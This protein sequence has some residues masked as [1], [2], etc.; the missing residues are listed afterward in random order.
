MSAQVVTSVGGSV[1]TITINRS[2]SPSDLDGAARAQLMLSLAAVAVDRTVLAVV[3]RGDGDDFCRGRDLDEY[4]AR[5]AADLV[6]GSR[7]L[8]AQT[9]QV[10]HAL[11][12][13]PQPVIAAVRGRCAGEGLALALA[14]DLR[15]MADDASLNV[16]TCSMGERPDQ[17]LREALERV[18][19]VER[20]RELALSGR[21]FT[22]REAVEWG[23]VADVVPSAQV[24]D[25][26]LGQAAMLTRLPIGDLVGAKVK[27]AGAATRELERAMGAG[28]SNR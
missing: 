11:A 16:A 17:R 12:A 2:A 20:G 23:I 19:G 28:S 6:M 15:V 13:V 22:A 10:V 5:M 14:C 4:A 3:L 18:V 8:E 24:T 1:A 25:L 7:E 26:A 27:L 21:D 9:A